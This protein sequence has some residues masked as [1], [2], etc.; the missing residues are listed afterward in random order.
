MAPKYTMRIGARAR[1]R[2]A[3]RAR[4]LPPT[5]IC[6]PTRASGPPC[7]TP[8]AGRGGDVFT[9]HRGSRSCS[10]NLNLDVSNPIYELFR[11]YVVQQDQ[12]S[13]RNFVRRPAHCDD[14]AA[15]VLVAS[16][17]ICRELLE[18]GAI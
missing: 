9:M 15:V 7:K 8:A 4:T 12:Q 2:N 18:I 6:R 14:D 5:L 13:P 10:D 3:S 16:E 17:P 1:W 11:G